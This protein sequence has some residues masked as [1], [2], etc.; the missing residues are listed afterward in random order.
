MSCGFAACNAAQR[1]C[2]VQQPPAGAT[3]R[4]STMTALQRRPQF[5]I[6]DRRAEPRRNCRKA[7]TQTARSRRQ[8]EP[9]PHLHCVLRDAARCAYSRTGC[10]CGGT[11]R[12]AWFRSTF[13]TEWGFES[14]HPHHFSLLPLRST[15]ACRQSRCWGRCPHGT[16]PGLQGSSLVQHP[17]PFCSLVTAPLDA[18]LSPISGLG[19]LHT[20]YCHQHPESSDGSSG[21]LASLH[22]EHSNARLLGADSHIAFNGSPRFIASRSARSDTCVYI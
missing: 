21:K 16:R 20:Q 8:A 12:R 18:S 11:G 7:L 3:T 9:L 5:P 13:L 19:F 15:R 22:G 2:A 17:A 4:H 1:L 10:G 6:P 14:L